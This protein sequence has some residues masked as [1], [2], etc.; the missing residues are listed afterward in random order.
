MGLFNNSDKQRTGNGQVHQA[1]FFCLE[2]KSCA[3]AF[4][5]LFLNQLSF[6]CCSKMKCLQYLTIL[7][8]FLNGTFGGNYHSVWK[9]QKKSYSTLRAKRA[10]F[11][12]WVDKSSL[13][14][15]K[16]VHLGEFFFKWS[17]RWNNVTR[18]VNLNWRKIN[19]KCQNWKTKLGQIESTKIN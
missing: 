11:T 19:E 7:T 16:M 18:L 1:F 3:T 8:I 15:P 6:C 5:L 12:F 4:F 2:G 9:S 17:F 14:V 10:T 13:K